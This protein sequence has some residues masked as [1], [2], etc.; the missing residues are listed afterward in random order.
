M[1]NIRITTDRERA[2]LEKIT[3]SLDALLFNIERRLVKDD[4]RLN[5]G[6]FPVY[7]AIDAAIISC[8]A[9][10]EQEDLIKT[11]YYESEIDFD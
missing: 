11:V 8:R 10:L 9:A 1:I 3:D 5:E 6:E 2:A 4:I 7:D